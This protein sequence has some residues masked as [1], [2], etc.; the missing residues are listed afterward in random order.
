[1]QTDTTDMT[2][3]DAI[4]RMLDARGVACAASAVTIAASPHGSSCRLYNVGVDGLPPLL[5]KDLSPGALLPEAREVRPAHLYDPLREIAVYR[6]I[7]SPERIGPALYGACVERRRGRYLLLIERVDAMALDYI[8]DFDVWL[9]AAR[10]LGAM[11]ARVDGG[12]LDARCRRHLAIVDGAEM[13]FWL[14]RAVASAHARG[15]EALD[16]IAQASNELC[17]AF[18]RM[19]R[20]FIHG[21]L[22]ASNLLVGDDGSAAPIDWELAAIGPA[23]VDIAALSSG[24]WSSDERAMLVDAYAAGAGANDRAE[25]FR[26]VE[27]ARLYLALRLLGWSDGWMPPV[28]ERHDWRAEALAAFE[29]TVS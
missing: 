23:A 12:R 2:L 15:D 26:Q 4:A 24:A 13:R 7:L 10:W 18:D 9:G 17:S 28:D 8:G 6:L 5:L 22:F 20:T 21:E 16:D 11:H 1:M 27:L 19:P 25:L 29:R 14:E 3:A